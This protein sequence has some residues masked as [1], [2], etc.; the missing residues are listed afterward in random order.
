MFRC[1][2]YAIALV[3]LTAS[4]TAHEWTPTYPTPKASFIDGVWFVQMKLFNKREDTRYYHIEVFD[5]DWQ[6]VKITVIGS[7]NRNIVRIEYLTSR[8]LDVY[9]SERDKKNIEYVCSTSKILAT[10]VGGSVLKS[11]IC[12]R[13]KQL[14]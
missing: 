9:F 6:P 7:S 1:L 5:K 8:I 10:E 13:I 3:L 4:A 11:R 14:N 2:K 12:S